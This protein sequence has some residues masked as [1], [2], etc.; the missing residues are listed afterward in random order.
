MYFVV[1]SVGNI[2]S[3][4]VLNVVIVFYVLCFMYFLGFPFL[5]CYSSDFVSDHEKPF[6]NVSFD[7]D[8]DQ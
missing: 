3:K 1:F 8:F 7:F 5:F 6:G 4:C 2:H